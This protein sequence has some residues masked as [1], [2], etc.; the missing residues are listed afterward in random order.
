M[1]RRNKNGENGIRP[2][3]LNG[4]SQPQAVEPVLPSL[5]DPGP[6]HWGW[7]PLP[8]PAAVCDGG[9]NPLLASQVGG[10]KEKHCQVGQQPD[11]DQERPGVQHGAGHAPHHGAVGQQLPDLL[12]PLFLSA[13]AL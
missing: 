4:G 11:P 1:F 10:L 13:A 8:V 2:D 12:L 9:G 6:D 7:Q 3:P 5:A